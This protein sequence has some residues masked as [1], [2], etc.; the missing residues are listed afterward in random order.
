MLLRR[1]PNA[2]TTGDFPTFANPPGPKGD[3]P[4]SIQRF[5]TS[6]HKYRRWLVLL[7]SVAVTFGMLFFVFLRID[8]VIFV[9]LLLA[10]DRRLLTVAT[11]FVLL[12]IILGGERWRAILSAFT[13]DRVLPMLGVQA[14]FYSSTFFNC[15][16]F[17]TIGGDVAR[18]W[19]ARKFPLSIRQI[20]LS[21]LLDRI[22]TVAALMI[23]A[24]LTLPS[25]A[26]PL[27]AMASFACAAILISGILGFLLLQ[28]IT[29]LLG[30]WRDQ[31]FINS[32]INSAEELR[33][34]SRRSGLKSLGYALAS[35]SCAAFA[36]YC[37]AQ[38]LSIGISVVHMMAV[39]SLVIFIAALPISLA[40]WGVREI[41]FVTLL[42]LLGVDRE[43]ALLLSVEFGI[44]GTLMSLPGGVVW[45]TMGKY[46]PVG[47]PTK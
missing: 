30:R 26:H 25:I 16:P 9:R 39:I 46:R 44:I 36:A 18:V 33:F 13:D 42:G 43:A 1:P 10:Q 35:A 37:I 3:V 28:P 45:L 11:I 15:L 6:L 14:V 23:L 34:L 41:S 7:F 5:K 29:R 38:S 40:G 24:L 22:I 4:L 47:L 27:A 20:V 2:A 31:R 19:L 21:V 32:L 8:R 12:Q 17:G